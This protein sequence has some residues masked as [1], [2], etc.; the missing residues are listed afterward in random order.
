MVVFVIVGA[1]LIFT[2]GM[3]TMGIV[4]SSGRYKAT[5]EAYKLGYEKGVNAEKERIGNLTDKYTKDLEGKKDK[6]ED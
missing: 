5:T 1:V 3:V 4:V 6:G 2:S